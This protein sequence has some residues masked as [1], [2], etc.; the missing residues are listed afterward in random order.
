MR[1]RQNAWAQGPD[2]TRSERRSR[3]GPGTLVLAALV[4]GLLLGIPDLL[5]KPF[6]DA[7]GLGWP[8][9]LT[10][11]FGVV[12]WAAWGQRIR[13]L[14]RWW[15]LTLALFSFTLLAFGILYRAGH[16][17]WLGEAFGAG[18]SGIAKLTGL[19][20][21]GL[22]ALSPR[23]AGHF[24]VS[25]WKLLRRM[26][27]QYPLHRSARAGLKETATALGA[28]AA[29]RRRR[30]TFKP[31]FQGRSPKPS[32]PDSQKEAIPEAS[33]APGRSKETVSPSTVTAGASVSH[34][35]P[36]PGPNGSTGLP[37]LPWRL[38][39]YDLLQIKTQE[40]ELSPAAT[41]RRSRLI[42]EA[43]ASYGVNAKVV[44][45]KPGPTVTQFA[46]EPGWDIKT[47]RV[48]VKD[49]FGRA[50]LDRNGQ[51]KVKEEEVSR[52]RVK[53]ERITSLANDMALTLAAPSLR[54]EAPVPGQAVV[55]L[56]VPNST[57][58]IVPL[59]AAIESTAFQRLRQKSKLALGL[60][61]GVA[62]ESI[63]SD[64]AQMP[65]LLIAGAT[66][67]GKTVCLHSVV[68]TLL[69]N[70]T[71]DELRLLLIDPKRVEMTVFNDIPHL[72]TPVVVETDQAVSALKK[73]LAEM[74]ARFKKLALVKARNI[75]AYNK[76]PKVDT[77]LPYLVVVIDELAD[78]M[79]TSTD[80]VEPTLCR[81][82]QLARAT[83]IH[84]VVAT[85][86]PSVDVVTG[87]IKANF[88][89]RISF[90]VAS[91]IDSRTI[92]DTVGADKLLGKGDMLFLPAEADKPKRL[93]GSYLTDAEIEAVAAFWKEQRDRRA[94]DD[95]LAQAFAALEPAQEGTND[96]LFEKA[97]ELATQHSRI[98]AS[99]IQRRLRIGYPRAARLMDLLEEQGL[100]KGAQ[101]EH[102]DEDEKG[103]E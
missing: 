39:G 96:P 41:E 76:S 64:L 22:A 32:S 102:P 42:E 66:G 74:D 63:V 103:G 13:K 27:R 100:V 8:L 91:Q 94:T 99:L 2:R 14:L 79:M 88:P 67:S 33:A 62:G 47:R 46:V 36:T 10:A 53:V 23:R 19:A 40:K 37:H 49:A 34:A 101:T 56:E 93:Q 84:L 83:G 11:L 12:V 6:W 72:I 7:L 89:C 51:P 78:L 30:F 65:H 38:P 55:G 87:L 44:G 31:P 70:A 16:G 48:P 77:P 54:I 90:A 82:A 50:V 9:L 69:M 25:S 5:G 75:E 52:T 80:V 17:G 28:A 85:Q 81:L 24:V 29:H 15:N 18:P 26:Y 35:P 68:V 97:K 1:Q 4:L 73:V 21:A 45:V 92:L 71:P 86:R 60:G 98:S 20:L 57:F 3:F 61:Q 58:T 95:A 59:R 43:L